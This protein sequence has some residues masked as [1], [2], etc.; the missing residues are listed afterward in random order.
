MPANAK[1]LTVERQLQELGNA[2]IGN[3]PQ[4]TIDRRVPN[5]RRFTA[6]QFVAPL[7]RK[8]PRSDEFV[9]VR[10]RDLSTGGFSYYATH[11]PE[12][13]KVICAFGTAP[14]FLYLTAQVLYSKPVTIDGRAAYL[15]GCRFL[16]KVNYDDC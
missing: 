13:G 9:A 8:M 1:R 2:W 6:I 15:I 4:Q 14:D 7:G 10:C 11:P 16:Q 12:H 5:R 3:E